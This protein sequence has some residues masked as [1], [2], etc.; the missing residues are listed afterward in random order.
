MGQP[1]PGLNVPPVTCTCWGLGFVLS[2]PLP[3]V[4]FPWLSGDFTR[5]SLLGLTPRAP[6]QG[7]EFA[8]LKTPRKPA[9]ATLPGLGGETEAPRGATTAKKLRSRLSSA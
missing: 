2:L 1:L 8:V 6:V 3:P 9:P 5:L 4:P 7:W